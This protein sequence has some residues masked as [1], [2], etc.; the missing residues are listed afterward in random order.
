MP[1]PLY[2]PPFHHPTVQ[3]RA[4][5]GDPDAVARMAVL[6][7]LEACP[8]DPD[9]LHHAGCGCDHAS[10][11]DPQPCPSCGGFNGDCV[12]CLPAPEVVALAALWAAE[13]QAFMALLAV[14]GGGRSADLIPEVQRR[15]ALFRPLAGAWSRTRAIESVARDVAVGVL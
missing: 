4:A 13:G 9:G 2:F 6:A 10:P 3:E 14:A 8:D 7:E 12:D 11:D 1:D 15:A 5:R